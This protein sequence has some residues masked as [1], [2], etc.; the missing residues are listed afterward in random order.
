MHQRRR[1]PD[2]TRCQSSVFRVLPIIEEKLRVIRKLILATAS[3]TAGV[4]RIE[5]TLKWEEPAYLT[6]ESKSGSTIRLGW[7]ESVPGQYAIYFN[8]RTR[9][10]IVSDDV[11]G[12][13]DQ[14]DRAIVFDVDDDLPEDAVCHC[15]E[16]ALTCHRAKWDHP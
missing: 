4:G 14:G 3:D 8:C 15:I 2:D 9:L 6:N 11:P 10:W 1:E 13:G 16:M 7:K 5:E 12:I